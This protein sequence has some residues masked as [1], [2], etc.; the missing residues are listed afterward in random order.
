MKEN[1]NDIRLS[2]HF[3]LIEFAHGVRNVVF[4]QTVCLLLV[5]GM[6]YRGC[7]L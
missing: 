3:K 1:L 4:L 5:I 2:P 7:G 6:M